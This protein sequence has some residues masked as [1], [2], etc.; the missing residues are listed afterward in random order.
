MWFTERE[1]LKAE[2]YMNCV[3]ARSKVAAEGLSIAGS[4]LS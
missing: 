4:S 1:R 3:D 2:S